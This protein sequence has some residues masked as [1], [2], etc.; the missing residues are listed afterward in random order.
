MFRSSVPAAWADSSLATSGLLE[1][2]R[3]PGGHLIF[4]NGGAFSSRAG[5]QKTTAD[6]SAKAEV[7]EVYE[8]TREVMRIRKIFEA[9]GIPL[10]APTII[11]EDNSSAISILQLT[12]NSTRARHFEVKYFWVT[13]QLAKDQIILVKCD[14]L[15]MLADACTKA[16]G[17]ARFKFMEFW[18]QGLHALSAE[19]VSAY[20][21]V[22]PVVPV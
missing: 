9:L 15:R 14:T 5:L 16:L 7:I 3:S 2:R 11:H 19:E 22:L 13:E 4:I 10:A 12:S 21:Y 18:V 17:P 20:G 6:S 1:F 8:C